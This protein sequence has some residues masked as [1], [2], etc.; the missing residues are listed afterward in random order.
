MNRT[1]A[2]F[3]DPDLVL[4]L[5]SFLLEIGVVPSVIATGGRFAKRPST[6]QDDGNNIF[7]EQVRA[8]DTGNQLG[9]V[10]ILTDTDYSHIEAAIEDNKPT[11]MIGTSKGYRIAKKLEIPLIRV[12]FPIHDRIGA[13]RIL[14]VGYQGALRLYDEIANSI[15]HLEQER[16]SI[17]FSYM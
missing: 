7:V 13:N 9:D 11:F 15:L 6:D 5:V 8:I 3:G 2:V 14:H 17:G 10:S 16:S 12:G 1:A 4:G